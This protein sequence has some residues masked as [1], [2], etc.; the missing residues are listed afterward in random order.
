LEAHGASRAGL[1]GS[2]ACQG[3]ARLA[4][5]ELRKF[6]ISLPLESAAENE[7]RLFPD[8]SASFS[9]AQGKIEFQ[10]LDLLSGVGSWIQG[11]GSVDFKRNLDFNLRASSTLPDNPDQPLA[12]FHVGG[13]LA[14]PEVSPVPAASPLRRSRQR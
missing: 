7:T 13:T 3:R 11:T 5:A 2:L 6:D 8:G 4:N 1:I 14:A 9:C 10:K 12:A